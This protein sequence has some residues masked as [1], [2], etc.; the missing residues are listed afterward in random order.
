[1]SLTTIE[2][3]YKGGRV[4]LREQPSD[5]PEGPVLVTFLS[6]R[7]DHPEGQMIR[8]GMFKELLAVSDD[9]FRAAECRD[10]SGLEP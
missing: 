7:K 1:M 9:D 6:E 2:A 8:F 10:V 4:E 5:L 3:T